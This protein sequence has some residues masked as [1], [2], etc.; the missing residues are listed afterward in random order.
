MMIAFALTFW[1]LIV[2]LCAALWVRSNKVY[3]FRVDLIHEIGAAA[4]RDIAAG[5][6]WR[7]RYAAYDEVSYNDMAV[8]FWKPLDSFYDREWLTG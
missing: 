7:W 5:R 2:A 8:K 6:D 3:Q 4:A 1:V